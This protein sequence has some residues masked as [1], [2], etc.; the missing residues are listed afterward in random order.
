[1]IDEYNAGAINVE[2]LFDRLV[3]FAREL[4]Q[5]EKRSIAEN[6]T[7]EELAI[8]DILTKPEIKLTGKEKDQVRKAAR[9]MLNTLKAEKLVLDWRKRQ[10]SRAQVM[11]TIEDILDKALPDK[12]TQD[13]FHQKCDLIYQHI[14]DSYFGEGRSVYVVAS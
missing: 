3:E 5:E 12:F 8:F 4:N 13:M 9:D 14:Y 7:E 10:Q 6:L 1:M 2:L 11:V